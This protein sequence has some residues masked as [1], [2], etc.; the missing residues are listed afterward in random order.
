MEYYWNNIVRHSD[1]SEEAY[2][3][4]LFPLAAHPADLNAGCSSRSL[5]SAAQ[6]WNKG[7]ETA[8]QNKQ[9][10]L[11]DRWSWK[12]WLVLHGQ[13]MLWKVIQTTEG[14]ENDLWSDVD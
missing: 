2:V 6:N 5:L 7:L 13:T 10:P 8:N 11:D 3:Y 14:A 9:Q 12:H 1:F 4:V